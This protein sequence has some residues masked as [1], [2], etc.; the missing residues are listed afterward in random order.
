MFRV[1]ESIIEDRPIVTLFINSNDPCHPIYLLI[2]IL[3]QVCF[4]NF[5]ISAMNRT[6]CTLPIY[7]LWVVQKRYANVE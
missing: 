2:S 4:H 7:C 3:I 6:Q 1:M 5:K